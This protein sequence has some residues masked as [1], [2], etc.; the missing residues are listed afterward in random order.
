MAAPAS[1]VRTGDRADL[2]GSVE[3]VDRLRVVMIRIARRIR[4][5]A[6]GDVSPSQFAVLGSIIEHGPLTNGQI[7]ERE[8]V[9]ASTSSKIVDAL[10]RAGLVQRTADPAD[11][12]CVQI[13]VTE[14]GS[15]YADEVRAAGRTW[16]AEQIDCL[17]PDDVAAIEAALPALERLLAGEPD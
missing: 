9:R 4:S 13:T 11:R 16:L 6:Q 14:A 12:R 8:H 5:R 7:A 1:D 10:E 2:I 17:G 15:S 3:S